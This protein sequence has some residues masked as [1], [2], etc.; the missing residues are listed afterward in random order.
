MGGKPQKIGK[1][2]FHLDYQMGR[3]KANGLFAI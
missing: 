3:A 1:K 2:M